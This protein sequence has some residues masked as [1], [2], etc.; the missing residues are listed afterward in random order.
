MG[1]ELSKLTINSSMGPI[2]AAPLLL[3]LV[4]LNVRNVKSIYVQTFHLDRQLKRFQSVNRR[5]FKSENYAY[6]QLKVAYFSIALSILQQVKNEFCRLHRPTTLS[7][8]VPVLG[9]SRPSNTPTK[10]PEGD[11]LLVSQHV[12]QIPLCFN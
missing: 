1:R 8:G 10:S 6:Q 9:L 3:C 11:C 5:E 7:V 4:D 12:L 2:G